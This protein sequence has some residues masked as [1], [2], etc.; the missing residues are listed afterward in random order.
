MV[1]HNINSCMLIL[2]LSE[3]AIQII[4]ANR[5]IHSFWKS[6]KGKKTG[7]FFISKKTCMIQISSLENEFGFLFRKKICNLVFDYES[8]PFTILKACFTIFK[9]LK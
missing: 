6:M 1:L 2:F 4:A 3:L 8:K 7:I 5:G 9:Y